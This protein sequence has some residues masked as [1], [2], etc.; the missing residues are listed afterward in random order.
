MPCA[1]KPVVFQ[2][3]AVGTNASLPI[4]PMRKNVP[5]GTRTQIELYVEAPRMNL[6]PIADPEHGLEAY[7]LL[8]DV[9]KFV[10]AFGGPADVAN[11]SEVDVSE[12]HLIVQHDNDVFV[13]TELE[14]WYWWSIR[15]QVIVYQ[16]YN[17]N[18]LINLNHW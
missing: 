8:P 17:N 3:L 9:P 14:R 18:W 10:F 1:D 16:L 13:Q 15:K 2:G 12:A 7:A 4:Y 11:G 5:Q 6:R